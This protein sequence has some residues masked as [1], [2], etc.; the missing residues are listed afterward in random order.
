MGNAGSVA[1]V[2]IWSQGVVRREAQMAPPVKEPGLQQVGSSYLAAYCGQ[3]CRGK[4]KETG[5]ITELSHKGQHT[6]SC[7]GNPEKGDLGS[8]QI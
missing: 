8:F 6:G 7:N 3:N 2:Q 1:Q 4:E 5:F